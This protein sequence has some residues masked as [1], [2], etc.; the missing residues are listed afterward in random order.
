MNTASAA[1]AARG[2]VDARFV[3]Q[4]IVELRKRE[5]CIANL[6]SHRAMPDLRWPDETISYFLSQLSIMDSNNFSG[7]VGAGEREGRIFSNLVRQRHYGFGHGIGRSGDVVAVQPKAA[8]SSLL[9]KLTNKL[10]LHAIRVCGISRADAAVVLPTATGLSMTLVLLALLDMRRKAASPAGVALTGLR[11]AFATES[12]TSSS[13][14]H[15]SPSSMPHAAMPLTSPPTHVVWS[16]IDQK[17]C[18]KAMLA[19]GLAVVAVDPVPDPAAGSDALITDIVGIEAAVASLPPGA[20][21]AVVTTSSCF[22]PRAPDD[23]VGVARLCGRLGV[24]HIV[25]NA[26]GLQSSS[27]CHALNEACRAGRVDAFVQST[28]KN[29]L[30]PVGGAI[31]AAPVPSAL[32]TAVSRIYPGRASLAPVLDLF[33]TLLAMVRVLACWRWCVCLPAGDG[34]CAC[35][36]GQ[37]E[38]GKL[39]AAARSALRWPFCIWLPS[40]PVQG[41]GGLKA[42]L[43]Q[44]KAVAVAL[45]A[46]LAEVGARYGE[47]V[48]E[49]RAN[50]ISFALTLGT[51]T[52]DHEEDSSGNVYPPLQQGAVLAAGVSA[53]AAESGAC[54]DIASARSSIAEEG[55][56]SSP[57]STSSSRPLSLVVT[58]RSSLSV[59]HA[60]PL[61]G[62]VGSKLASLSGGTARRPAAPTPAPAASAS[63][64][65]QAAA[66]Y[67]G[68]ML[69]SRGVSGTRVVHPAAVAS[70]DGARFEGYGASAAGYPHVYLTAAAALGMTLE[71]VEVFG[72]RLERALAEFVRQRRR[73]PPAPL[74]PEGASSGAAEEAPATPAAAAASAPMLGLEMAAASDR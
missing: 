32:L 71:D 29:F 52:A 18:Y 2:M 54:T 27:A 24:P 58:E 14:R 50:A 59:S 33:I 25:N 42:L 65:A 6:L 28:D 37:E 26:Y 22:A 45:K 16:R 66:T 43:T 17:S 31:V 61:D 51:V 55:G 40:S 1:A 13:A 74:R 70:I 60:L 41:V 49:S 46:K 35:S 56:A 5:D 8:G 23:V 73:Q 21:L 62:V 63:A 12:S 38:G 9:Y 19:A 48:L 68:S 67:L 69:F 72:V 64:A 15:D 47:R 57:A 44:R 34:A 11:K 10:A 30:V 4:G 20:V 39:S 53:A 36:V 7:S 3:D